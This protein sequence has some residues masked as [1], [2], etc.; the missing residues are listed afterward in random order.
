MIIAT[1]G[2]V[3]HGKTL[4]VKALTGVDA[5]RLPEE[6]KRGMTIDLGFAYWPV[7]PDTTIGFVDVPGHERFI[8]NMLCGVTG[9]DFVLLVIAADDGIMPQTREHLA[10]IDLLGVPRGT[11]ALTKS[12]RVPSDRIAAVTR[13]VAALLAGTSL[14]EAPILPVSAVTGV[15][16]EALKANLTDAARATRKADLHGHFRL[17]IDRSFNIAGAGLVVTGTVFSGSV[18]IGDSVRVLQADRQ[19]R[20]RSIHAQNTESRLGRTGQRCALNLTGSDLQL[21]LVRRGDWVVSS[22]ASR[23]V[24]KL[25]ARLRVLTSEARPLAHWMPVHIHLGAADVTGRN[26]LLEGMSLAPGASGL[27]QLVLDHPIGAVRGDRVILRDQSAQRTIGG[28]VVIDIYPPRRGRSKPERLTYLRAMAIDDHAASLA[29]LLD[30]CP[31]GLDLEQFAGN[32]NLTARDAEELFTAHPMRIVATEASRLGFAPVHW[33]RL[34]SI[35]L[36]ALAAWH[37]RSPNAVGP[38]EDRI[39]FGTPLRLPRETAVAVA[40]ELIRDGAIIRELTGVRLP[41]HRA[42]LTAADAAIWRRIEPMLD[43][44]LLRP[45]SVHEMA[46]SLGEDAKKLEALLVRVARLGLLVRVAPNR[47]LRPETLRQLGEM[48]A[49][50]AAQSPDHSVTAASFRDV[51]G[52]GRN[53]AIELLEYFDRVKLT[54]RV[55]D[56]HEIVRPVEQAFRMGRP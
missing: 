20:V 16:I 48:A 29:A 10:I 9:I 12:D 36:T 32:R 6:K 7:G 35:A 47:F 31:H 15:G 4:L 43:P 26:A 25:D 3:D 38:S 46:A 5:D 44:K 34:K 8:H 33:E 22:G 51:A 56:A 54:R 1:A 13:D 45:P 11:V 14:A 21:D 37:R 30:G 53:L 55:G 23:P 18:A 40:A 39:F 24:L 28:G 52:V 19:A 49:A 27:V 42:T 17:A 50:L 41:S 2:H